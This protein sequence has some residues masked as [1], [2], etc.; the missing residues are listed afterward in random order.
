MNKSCPEIAPPGRIIGHNHVEG[1]ATPDSA[2]WRMRSISD[3]KRARATAF[4]S[5]S[6]TMILPGRCCMRCASGADLHIDKM[7]GGFDFGGCITFMA[8]DE[9]A[10]NQWRDF[11]IFDSTQGG[12]GAAVRVLH[13]D[14]WLCSL[15]S[16][17]KSHLHGTVFEDDN[18]RSDEIQ[19]SP[20]TRETV[21]GLHVVSYNLRLI[22]EF[23]ERASSST[24]EEQQH[25]V[26]LLDERLKRSAREKVWSARFFE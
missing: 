15:C 12:Q 6:A 24:T 26:R 25:I 7:D 16:L 5:K 17:Y 2:Y 18:G 22:E 21:H 1:H 19:L 10:G 4:V 23:C 20:H 11:A 14:G 3:A 8:S 13:R 9:S